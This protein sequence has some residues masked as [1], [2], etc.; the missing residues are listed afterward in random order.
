MGDGVIPRIPVELRRAE[1]PPGVGQDTIGDKTVMKNVMIADSFGPF[2]LK[3][4]R[5]L[6]GQKTGPG[7]DLGLGGAADVV[8]YAGLFIHIIFGAVAID[9]FA[10]VVID[11]VNVAAGLYV[12]GFSV[13]V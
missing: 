4:E 9:H 13:P 3:I 2:S 1:N 12:I 11:I 5:I 7:S 8:I 10:A 6:R